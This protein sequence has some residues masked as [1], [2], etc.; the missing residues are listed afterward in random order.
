MH[1]PQNKKLSLDAMF[2]TYESSFPEKVKWIARFERTRALVEAVVP[3]L[4]ETRWRGKSDFYS[5][6]LAL[7]ELSEGKVLTATK[8][9]AAARSLTEFGQLVTAR[10]S[11]EGARGRAARNLRE[12]SEAVEKA[13]SDRDRRETR[14][15]VLKKL[16]A[17]YFT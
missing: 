13:A 11:K 9:R 5:L 10:L 4:R 17:P 8:Q 7:G 15:Q 3:N 6:F 2:S 1:G 16:L 14:H 12:Y